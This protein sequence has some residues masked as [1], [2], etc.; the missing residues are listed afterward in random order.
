M[1]KLM[2][3]ILLLYGAY[4]ASVSLLA[5]L[6]RLQSVS[7][8]RIRII[9]AISTRF[10]YGSTNAGIPVYRSNDLPHLNFPLRAHVITATA[11]G[12][13]WMRVWT[14]I[15]AM[16]MAMATVMATACNGNHCSNVPISYAQETGVDRS[17]PTTNPDTNLNTNPNT[18]PTSKKADRGMLL[19][20]EGTA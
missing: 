3:D 20:N 18:N 17:A 16:V 6:I 2:R 1:I 10:M 13:Q 14:I 15:V 11:T 19:V 7:A 4:F 12:R 5:R 8:L 9:V